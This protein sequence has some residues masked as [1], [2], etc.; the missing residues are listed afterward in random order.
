MWTPPAQTSIKNLKHFPNKCNTMNLYCKKIIR[1]VCTLFI[2][3][4]ITLVYVLR[5]DMK[6]MIPLTSQQ[7]RTSLYVM[8]AF[9]DLW[10][11]TNKQ[12]NQVKKSLNWLSLLNK[13]CVGFGLCYV[14]VFAC[15]KILK[16]IKSSCYRI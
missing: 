1:F 9:H 14:C 7:Q 11:D 2:T 5:F 3:C 15:V 8:H 12:V 16:L 13:L 6:M 4:A 10:L